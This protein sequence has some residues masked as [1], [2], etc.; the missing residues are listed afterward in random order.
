MSAASQT[1][2]LPSRMMH[3]WVAPSVRATDRGRAAR[4]PLGL[5]RLEAAL[6]AHGF[7]GHEVAIVP[8]E[9]LE[10]VVTSRTRI[11]G[12]SS[13][14][15]L[16]CGMNSTT[17]AA[18]F[19][20]APITSHCCGR[21]IER[22]NRLRMM[23]APDA[24]LVLGGPG[25]WQFHDR[26][27]ALTAMGIDHLVTGYAEAS[28]P[29]LVEQLMG[30]GSVEAVVRGRG[31]PASELPPLAGPTVMGMVEVSRGCGWGCR[32]CTLSDQ[33]MAHLLPETV[34]V[35][36]E[37]NLSGGMANIAL[38]SEDFFRYGGRGGVVSADSII[39][40][41]R[42]V[43]RLEGVRTLS[44]DHANIA[45]IAAIDDAALG[46]IGQLLRGGS[47]A[48][49]GAGGGPRPWVNLGVET[50]SGRLLAS[51]GGGRK[52]QPFGVDGWAD[53]CEEQIR[54]LV[55]Q[56]YFPLV[57]LVIGLAGETAEDVAMTSRWVERLADLPL[58]V[59]P[60]LLA[61]LGEADGQ[62]SWI[63]PD[64]WALLGQG[65]EMTFRHMPGLYW[66][67]H[68]AAGVNVFRRIALQAMG[69]GYAL[70]WRGRQRRCQRRAGER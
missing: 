5:R 20:G 2:W 60:L 38:G 26:P 39:D 36:V 70:M 54:R 31:L 14:D 59:V 16:G 1:T 17:V 22:I 67:H 52:M 18:L 11:I 4:A 58:A 42:N 46:E 28:F 8:P 12:V 68:G 33:P 65:M 51:Q 57:S 63:R 27:A 55:K 69:K 15:P 53:A 34:L 45:S 3:W 13:G 32:F 37:T 19:G 62:T 66:E 6:L 61:P 50:A 64:Q 48:G 23:R 35:D 21:L 10:R 29:E 49:A 40:L 41:L 44:I 30:G 24:R 56:G 47:G 9:A 25:A 7:E 43:R